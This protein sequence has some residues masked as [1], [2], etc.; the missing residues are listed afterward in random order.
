LIEYG[1]HPW[2]SIAAFCC[3]IEAVR[4][5]VAQEG[6]HDG[7]QVSPHLH[8]LAARESCAGRAIHGIRGAEEQPAFA[9]HSVHLPPADGDQGHGEPQIAQDADRGRQLLELEVGRLSAVDGEF[10]STTPR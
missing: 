9:P 2:A 10:E 1:C 4:Q 6:D 8:A 3:D 7:R 5:Q